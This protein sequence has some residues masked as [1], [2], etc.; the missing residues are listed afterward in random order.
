MSYIPTYGLS[1]RLSAQNTQRINTINKINDELN[2]TMNQLS[3]GYK[4]TS[5]AENP[6][7]STELARLQARI[8]SVETAIANNEFSYNALSG[9]D[10]A[11][12]QILNTLMDMRSQILDASSSTDEDIRETVLGYVSASITAV[13]VF[14]NA[15]DIG[16]KQ[17]LAGDAEYDLSRAS[18][19][20]STDDS[21]VRTMLDDTYLS[22]S[23]DKN[24]A[25]EQA[26]ISGT[27]NLPDSGSG[28]ADSVFDITT[29]KGTKRIQINATN[30]VDAEAK[31]DAVSQMNQ[32]L[33]DL[34]VYVEMSN[35][36][37]QLNFLTSSY[38]DNASISFSHVS[39]TDILNGVGS[40]S[41]TGKNGTVLINGKN[42]NL[43][44]KYK[45]DGSE[46]AEVSGEYTD[47]ITTDAT[48][49]LTTTSGT[50][51]YVFAGGDTVSGSL[52]AMNTA[53]AAI[54]AEVKIDN[55]ELV[56]KTTGKGNSQ[57]LVYSNT[58][59]DQIFDDGT[60]FTDTGRDYENTDGIKAFVAN[61]EIQAELSFSADKVGK[62]LVNSV[63]LDNQRFSFQPE[64]GVHFHISEGTTKMDSINYGFRDISASGL[65]LEQLVD[66]TSE[67]YLVDDPDKALKFLDSAISLVRNEWA[68]LGS[69][70]KNNLQAQTETLQ[71]EIVALAEERSTIA[72]V[73]E[74]Y[75]TT[76]ITKLQI[77]QQANISALSVAS[78]SAKALTALL[79]SG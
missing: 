61:T 17:V 30:P 47:A 49:T 8:S 57:V 52:T 18:G 79:P 77:L 78:S 74:A 68:G 67:F 51:S 2:T 33:E 11:Q 16:G 34:G 6:S 22:L 3:T 54:G 4:F 76:R 40:A 9:I 21:Y 43:A 75:A 58:G 53:F 27:F 1:T 69:F 25:T 38:G 60:A 44:G 32:E 23:F 50:A 10:S 64:G 7:G 62:D 5:A 66:S 12:S 31:A 24:N 26:V 14:S 37:T 72:D 71:D 15:V 36:G 65:G 29:S 42:Y 19:V 59:T 46:S 28:D 48:V 45:N 39:G 56:F 13:N 41:D 70:M 63:A 35:D 73:D 20:I 55:G